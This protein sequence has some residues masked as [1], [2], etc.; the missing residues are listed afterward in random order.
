MTDNTLRPY[1]SDDWP[2]EPGA[3]SKIVSAAVGREVGEVFTPEW[4]EVIFGEAGLPLAADTGT[5]F[6]EPP[7][8]A[9]SEA[10]KLYA[11]QEQQDA[12]AEE[13]A[14]TLDNARHLEGCYVTPDETAC[15]CVIGRL[16]AMLPRCA[17]TELKNKPWN[18]TETLTESRQCL[19]TVHPSA[20]WK[21]VYGEV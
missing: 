7:E 20:A 6:A 15:V 10:V 8:C 16:R 19:R 11:T 21:H 9:T 18:E 3:V 14:D 1:R 2:G 5:F 17:Y 4:A 12:L 13:L